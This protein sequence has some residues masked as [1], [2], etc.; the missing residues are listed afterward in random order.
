[1]HFYCFLYLLSSIF[2]QIFRIFSPMP[3]VFVSFV[4]SVV[5]KTH[6]RKIRSIRQIR[7][8]Y[9][10]D[11]PYNSALSHST[12]AHGAQFNTQHSTFIYPRCSLQFNIEQFNMRPR[13]TIQHS[14]FNTQHSSC[15][16]GRSSDLLPRL[17]W[18]A[19][20]CLLSSRTASSYKQK[21]YLIMIFNFILFYRNQSSRHSRYWSALCARRLSRHYTMG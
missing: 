12:C 11:I 1:M 21:K 19:L 15:R 5:F 17:S 2:A 14:T 18:W 20:R 10:L 6:Q 7:C 3:D 8:E 13:R 16:P 4:S 9:I